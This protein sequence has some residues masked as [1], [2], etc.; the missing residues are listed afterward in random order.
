MSPS[1][2]APQADAYYLF[3]FITDPRHCS[4]MSTSPSS[5]VLG[6]STILQPPIHRPLMGGPPL[7]EPGT[8]ADPA[9][10]E[11][12]GIA[13]RLPN[14]ALIIR[15]QPYHGQRRQFGVT[16][17]SRRT[18]TTRLGLCHASTQL[19]KA[20][21]IPAPP[22][23]VSPSRSTAGMSQLGTPPLPEAEHPRLDPGKAHATQ[24]TLSLFAA[25]DRTVQW[26]VSCTRIRLTGVT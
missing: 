19:D 23:A 2:K 1:L 15:W 25:L 14:R 4:H 12:R 18:Q 10:P 11:I 26:T 22:G 24:F 5:E 16:S 7:L 17:L 13:S 3:Q 20:V 6:R 8:C 21:R 9:H